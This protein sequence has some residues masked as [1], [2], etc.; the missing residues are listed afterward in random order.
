MQAKKYMEIY[1]LIIE[2]LFEPGIRLTT[3]LGWNFLKAA[4]GI[5]N[6]NDVLMFYEDRMVFLNGEQSL[7]GM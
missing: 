6:L 1:V 3:M 7:K 5:G 2:G 4:F